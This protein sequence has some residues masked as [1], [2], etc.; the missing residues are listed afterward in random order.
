[1]CPC[2]G[3]WKFTL[4]V[5]RHFWGYGYHKGRR[6]GTFSCD[7]SPI[8]FMFLASSR[9]FVECEVLH[10]VRLWTRVSQRKNGLVEKSSWPLGLYCEVHESIFSATFIFFIDFL[11]SAGYK[12]EFK[13]RTRE[14]FDGCAIFYRFPME[15]LAY[16][17]IEYFLG[18]NTV[19]D[20]DNIGTS[21]VYLDSLSKLLTLIIMVLV[22]KWVHCFV[23]LIH[24]SSSLASSPFVA[25][26]G[27][28]WI[29]LSWNFFCVISEFSSLS[30]VFSKFR[31]SLHFWD[32]AFI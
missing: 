32:W 7:A 12:G 11:F 28:H 14:M 8:I 25:P 16:Q 17:P 19:L 10:L 27:L 26:V 24:L 9:L 22:L 3:E 31:D 13:K 20:R 1:M 2:W 15:L 30:Y 6:Y 18:V 29:P 21:T 23:V 4:K 5:F